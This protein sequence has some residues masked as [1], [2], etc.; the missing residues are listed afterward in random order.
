MNELKPEGK[1]TQAAQF[2]MDF[3]S[4][5]EQVGAWEALTWGCG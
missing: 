2:L 4:P 1:F 3:R 5:A